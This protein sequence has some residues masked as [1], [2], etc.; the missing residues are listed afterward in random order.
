MKDTSD[1]ERR[2]ETRKWLWMM[3]RRSAD[4]AKQIKQERLIK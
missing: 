3:L 1:P 2:T 4:K